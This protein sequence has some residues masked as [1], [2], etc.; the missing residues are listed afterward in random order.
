MTGNDIAN[1]R[2]LEML[3]RDELLAA[4]DYYDLTV[5][6]RRVRAQSVDALMASEE[7]IIEDILV[8]LSRARL[9]EMCQGLNLKPR[10]KNKALSLEVLRDGTY[11]SRRSVQ[12]TPS[13]PLRRNGLSSISI[14]RWLCS[15]ELRA[16]SRMF[17]LA[18]LWPPPRYTGMSRE[19]L[20]RCSAF[21]R[22]SDAPRMDSSSA[23]EQRHAI[24]TGFN[25]WARCNQ[26]SLQMCKSVLSLLAKRL[27]PQGGR[28]YSNFCAKTIVM[29][30]QSK[31][32]AMASWRQLTRAR[33]SR[34][35]SYEG[36]RIS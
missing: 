32:K 31:W 35:W 21:V 9:K 22:K 14:L 33:M 7:V 20:T 16:V 6:D 19:K 5:E 34:H 15:W 18:T 23:P 3:R 8:D 10:G 36:F 13:L 11:W 29:H 24:Q 25:A 27:W 26:A 28:V 4:L 12:V 30:W 17:V 1:Q 2:I